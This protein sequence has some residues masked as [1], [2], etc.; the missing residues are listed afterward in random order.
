MK[1]SSGEESIIMEQK[2]VAVVTGATAGIGWAAARA[3]AERGFQ[4]AM[5]ARSTERCQAAAERIR[6]ACP[7]AQLLCLTADLSCQRQVRALADSLRAALGRVDALVLCAGTVSSHHLTTEDG[8]ELQ[9]AVNHL[10]GF[11]L[12]HELLELLRRGE[13][14]VITVSSG[15]HKHTRLTFPDVQHRHHYTLLGAYKRTKLCNV[16]FA[17]QANRL[18]PGIRAFAADPGLVRTDIGLKGTFGLER[19]V[20]RIR[21]ASGVDASRPGGAVAWLAAEE[22]PL[23]Q[24]ALYWYDKKPAKPSPYAL[25]EDVAAQLWQASER[26]CAIEPD[27]WNR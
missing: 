24:S 7:G 13:G 6:E 8:V 15:S 26:L 9:F 17:A 10:A 21:M 25:R 16:L 2:R 23:R 14:R 1:P 20:W 4:V 19:L 18:L 12:T 22:E 3:L 5:V 11:L 27:S